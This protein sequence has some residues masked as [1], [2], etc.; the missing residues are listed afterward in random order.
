MLLLSLYGPSG[1]K[2]VCKSL[3]Y[4][5][6]YWLVSVLFRT[7]RHLFSTRIGTQKPDEILCVGIPTYV[8][9]KMESIASMGDRSCSFHRSMMMLSLFTVEKRGRTRPQAAPVM[10][11]TSC[12]CRTRRPT[13]YQQE[14]LQIYV[15]SQT[16]FSVASRLSMYPNA[17]AQRI[18]YPIKQII[19]RASTCR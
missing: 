12:C 9:T 8:Q 11:A 6:I 15:R 2:L 7:C 1:P 4:M 16:H 5:Q 18:Q 3:L 13:T 19:D 10:L 17:T 14:F